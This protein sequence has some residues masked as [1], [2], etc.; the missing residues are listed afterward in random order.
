MA[1]AVLTDRRRDAYWRSAA[2]WITAVVFSIVV[3]PHLI[4]LVHENFPPI[5]WVTMRRV[6]HSSAELT[7]SLGVYVG[8]TIGYA[9]GSL[10]LV[11]TVIHPSNAAVRDS[12][13]ALEP[14]RRTATVLFW[15][16][17][18]LPIVAALAFRTD[19]QSIWN[20]PGLNLLPV[21]MLASPLVQ[22]TRL[23]TAR[24]A[25]IV[26]AFTILAIAASPLVAL[27][28]LKRGVENNAAYAR[29]LAAAAERQW[30]DS[31]EAPLRLVAGRFIIVSAV[32]FYVT[33]K[34]SIYSD[35]SNYLSPW[36]SDARIAEQG[37]AIV[38]ADD[39][40]WCIGKI[41]AY[42]AKNPAARRGAVAL[43]RRWLGLAGGTRHFVIGTVPPPA[44]PVRDT[45]P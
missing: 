22:V 6:A 27:T 37:M 42:A 11:A 21:M 20:G 10:A 34:P 44:T 45:A 3:L 4:W 23:Q 1:L 7:H 29:L 43:T 15:T 39:D 25:A 19:L 5:A 38:C 18:V 8:G 28:L 40:D 17:L 32:S 36:V 14:G 12:W 31:T 33:D 2:P 16:P 9:F 30:H 35:F 24:I 41:A 13:F 26:T